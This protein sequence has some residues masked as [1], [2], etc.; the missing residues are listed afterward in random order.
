M[1]LYIVPITLSE[2]IIGGSAIHL[3]SDLSG[4]KRSEGRPLE[5]VVPPMFSTPLGCA[6]Q[7]IGGGGRPSDVLT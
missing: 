6:S 5:G 1:H 7:N 3:S 2:G 4:V